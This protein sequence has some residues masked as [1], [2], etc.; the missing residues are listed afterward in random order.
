MN[1]MNTT[2][3]ATQENPN[4]EISVNIRPPRKNDTALAAASVCL[5]GCF[6]MRGI[7]IVDGSRGLF[8]SMPSRRIRRGGKAEYKDTC[9]PCTPEFRQQFNS[10]VLDAYRQYAAQQAE[11]EQNGQDESTPTQDAPEPEGQSTQ[12]PAS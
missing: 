4:R 11:Q 6:V 12:E 10:A 1:E 2:T 3:L 5:N 7:R 8:V 9:F